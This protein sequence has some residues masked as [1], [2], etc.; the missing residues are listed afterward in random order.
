[1][2]TGNGN[3]GNGTGNGNNGGDSTTTDTT[4]P[5]EDVILSVNSISTTNTFSGTTYSVYFTVDSVDYYSTYTPH[6][7]TFDS[8]YPHSYG[9]TDSNQVYIVI[10]LVNDCGTVSDTIFFNNS[11]HGYGN[12]IAPPVVEAEEKVNLFPN[13]ATEIIYIGYQI[14]ETEDNVQFSLINTNGE[15][16]LVQ[17]LYENNQ[18][19]SV[20]DVEPGVYIYMITSGNEVIKKS[21]LIIR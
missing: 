16:K 17:P 21:R 15:I 2:G 8:N 19:I 7:G 12:G 10:D 13:P 20:L 6:T 5:C 3:N 14:K 9:G 18:A 11:S 1:N 4:E